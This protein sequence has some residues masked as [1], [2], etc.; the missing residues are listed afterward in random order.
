MYLHLLPNLLPLFL[1]LFLLH[2]WT[3]TATVKKKNQLKKLPGT[4][5]LI[6]FCSYM[7]LCKHLQILSAKYLMKVVPEMCHAHQI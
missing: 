5:K 2:P 6:F 3:K 4:T 1:I 7:Y